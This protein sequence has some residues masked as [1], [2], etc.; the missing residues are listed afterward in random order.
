MIPT[1]MPGDLVLIDLRAKHPGLGAIYALW[2]GSGTVCKH[3]EAIPGADPP[4]LRIISANRAYSI[5]EV[6]AEWASIIGRVAWFW[7][8]T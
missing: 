4:T 7:R 5:Y 2:D 3:V 6:P 1:L 8:R